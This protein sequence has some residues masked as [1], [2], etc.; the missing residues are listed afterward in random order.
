MGI[1][2]ICLNLL[3]SSLQGL[4][5]DEELK[6]SITEQELPEL[7][8]LAKKHDLAH[9]VGDSLDKIGVL[10]ENSQARKV[11]LQERNMAVFRY[12]QLNYDLE[13]IS[14]GLEEEKIEHI[15]LK[16]S[17]IRKFY[18]E[19]WLRT[20]CDIDILIRESDKERAKE[21][22]ENKL[23]CEYKSTWDYEQ[24]FF[25]ESGTHI[26]LHHSLAC[27]KFEEK[28]F[29][30][31]IWQNA[32]AVDGKAYRKELADEW[33]YFYHFAHMAKHFE[34]GGCGIKPFMDIFVLEQNLKP[35]EEKLTELLEKGNMLAFANGVRALSKV[36]FEEREHTPTTQAL[37]E[38]IL[39]GGVYG[40]TANKV[41]AQQSKS[42]GKFKYIMSRIFQPYDLLRLNYPVLNKHKWLTPFYQV[43]RWFRIV[44]KGG[45]KKSV[46][47]FSESA[48]LS[49]DTQD[50][51]QKLLRD[52]GLM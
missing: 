32:V 46:I 22:F 24:S 34:T 18:P 1:K 38:F 50:K 21:V 41:K 13:R 28:K 39:T 27:G 23:N 11:F 15:P 36:W 20:S 30:S 51:T 45:A 37:E 29:L 7:F 44:F 43:V 31:E 52:L 6:N 17:V 33:F 4:D 47:E 35:D 9:I 5:L 8:K 16:G 26:E 19:P 14:A 40:T 42:G 3:K 12:E 48:N 49:K 10:K 2:E 25:T